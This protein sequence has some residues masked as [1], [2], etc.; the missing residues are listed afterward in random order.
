MPAVVAKHSGLLGIFALLM[1]LSLPADAQTRVAAAGAEPV[2]YTL[3][4]P[5]PETHYV[6]VEAVFP[7]E[8]RAQV[9]LSMA[10]WSP[11][12]YLVREYA[13]HVENVTATAADGAALPVEKTGKN[14]WRVRA[15]TRPRFTLSYRVYSREMGVRSNWVEAAFAML[16]GAPT[17]IT[18]ADVHAPQRPQAAPA[19][20]HEVRIAL[21]PRWKRSL[22]GL[23]DGN[24]ANTYVAPDFDTLV[25]SPIVVGNPDVHEFTVDGKRHYLVNTPAAPTFDG[26]RAARDLERLVQEQRK[27]WGFLPYDK[28]LFLNMITEAGGG[29]E[30]K[31]STLLMT[32]RWTTRTRRAYVSWLELC[33]HEYFHAWN[34]KRLRP[35]ELGPFDYGNEVYT[36]SLW[37]A[38]GFTDYYGE[39]L[40]HRA[41]LST[42]EEYLEALSNQIE[43]LQTTPGRLVQS[44]EAA[45]YD[46][47]IKQYRPDENSAN[48]SISYYTKGA[49]IAFL[50]DG[51]I[52]R[53][54]QGA[55]GL[56]DVMRAAYQQYSGARGYTPEQF[57]ETAE[58]VSGLD[59]QSFWDTVVEG[60]G[61][62]DYTEALAAFN[63]RF[64]PAAAP[65]PE[66]PAK[67][68]LGATT[69]NDG[70]RLIVSQVRRGTPGYDAGL[71][72][73]DEILA[74]DEYRVRAER[75]DSRLEQYRP[76]DRVSVLVAR[77]EQ[78]MR[79]DVTLGAEPPKTWRLE[80]ADHKSQIPNPDHKS[81]IANQQSPGSSIN[82]H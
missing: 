26:G 73:D 57:R 39:L 45:S 66:K 2:R 5:A 29:L 56:D 75:L 42:R 9:D 43:A 23:P 74:L 11:G 53:A 34:V 77:R 24:G 10:V 54:T 8:G 51:R 16:N 65:T 14:V 35:I 12:S 70:G 21:P 46:A 28:Y 48:V 68:W 20:Q 19:R 22:T 1:T 78:L 40:V 49:V 69:R 30:H 76:G 72:V 52:R 15:G 62:L 55:K 18:L 7:T 32:N 50:L 44:V 31:N 36:R 63:L 37:I 82:N 79:L 60:T 13:R 17:F 61:E 58:Q 47:W 67:A 25:D 6:E 38:E 41:G 59:L 80:D 33:S 27:M 71:N 4:F 64:K 81:R 3:S